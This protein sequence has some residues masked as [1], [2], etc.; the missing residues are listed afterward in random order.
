MAKLTD[1]AIHLA[2]QQGLA[3]AVKALLAEG[4]FVDSVGDFGRTPL[5]LAAEAG[6]LEVL[7]LLLD[8]GADVNARDTRIPKSRPRD[9][10]DNLVGRTAL[11]YASERGH[12]DVVKLL[13]ARGARQ[14]TKEADDFA[15]VKEKRVRSSDLSALHEAAVRGHAEIV[16]VLIDHGADPNSRADLSEDASDE[17][18]ISKGGSRGPAALS[19]LEWAI[20]GKQIPV[21]KLLV[22]MGADVN[23]AGGLGTTALHNAA[24]SIGDMEAT[25]FLIEQGAAVDA[26]DSRQTRPLHGAALA[27]R[28]DMVSCLLDHGAS[29]SLADQQG[30]TP[31]HYGALQLG[32]AERDPRTDYLA[33]CRLLI[34]HGAFLGAKD[35]RGRTPQDLAREKGVPEVLALFT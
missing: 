15:A 7:R 21:V 20:R 27:G 25:K 17:L 33:V 6:H 31:L 30:N 34:E 13:L 2:A 8:A 16:R 19:A 32:S 5:H 11:I 1:S 9:V 23:R 10:I 28:P 18:K 24:C 12:L 22:E 26:A 14:A 35:S 29:P 4:K 3:L